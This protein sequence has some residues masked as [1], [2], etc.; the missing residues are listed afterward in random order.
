M[1]ACACPNC[2]ACSERAY[3]DSSSYPIPLWSTRNG[4]FQII[5]IELYIGRV[6]SVVIKLA[7][8]RATVSN[9]AKLAATG[10]YTIY[11]VYAYTILKQTQPVAATPHITR[12]HPSAV[13]RFLFIKNNTFTYKIYCDTVHQTQ[14]CGW[15]ANHTCMGD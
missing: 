3:G 13:F 10:A 8:K 6:V 11:S 14:V 9:Y 1:A 5:N 12:L 7:G 2:I 4:L 15:S